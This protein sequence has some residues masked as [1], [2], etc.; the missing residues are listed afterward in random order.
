MG[1]VV[2][3]TIPACDRPSHSR[4]HCTSHYMKLWRY[5]DPNVDYSHL[6]GKTKRRVLQH[7]KTHDAIIASILRINT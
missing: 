5:G 4:G 2:K 6:A 3:C 1:A 7:A